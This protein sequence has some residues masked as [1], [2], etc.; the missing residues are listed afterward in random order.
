MTTISDI[1]DTAADLDDTLP[2]LG[3]LTTPD[4]HFHISFQ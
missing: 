2:F 1:P 3:I 4:A